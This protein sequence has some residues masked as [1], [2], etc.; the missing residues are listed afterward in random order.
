MKKVSSKKAW[1]FAVVSALFI[2]SVSAAYAVGSNTSNR[3]V[4]KQEDTSVLSSLI[5]ENRE[6]GKEETV[7]VLTDANGLAKKIIVSD[8]LK[9]TA[10]SKTISDYTELENVENIKG[11]ETYVMDKDNM[12]VW[13]AEGSDIYY[14]GT[15]D[16]TLPVDIKVSY[17]LDGKNISA[18]DL[19]GKSGRVTIRFDYQNNLEETVQIDGNNEIIHVPFVMLTGMILDN[20]HFKNIE[21]SNGKLINDA[22]KSLVMGFALPGLQDNLKLS[23]LELPSYVEIKADVE[24]FELTTTLSIATNDIFNHLNVENMNSAEDLK[25]ALND[26]SDASMQLVDGSSALYDGLSA[27]LSKSDELILGIDQLHKGS[28]Q[29]SDG[30]L[31]LNEG[32]VQLNSG[33][34]ELSEGLKL[35]ESNNAA[36]NGGAGQVFESLLAMADQQLEAAGLDVPLL[37]IENYQEVLESI[38]ASLDSDAIREMAYNTALSQ[39]TASIK[40]NESII[41]EQVE[42]EIR[43]QVLE[44]V[45]KAAG[46]NM[47]A[48]EYE[49]AL[50][51]GMIPDEIA[52]QIR[53]AVEMQMS[54][55]EIQNEISTVTEQKIEEL[56]QAAMQ[57]EEVLSK[58]EAAV[59]QAEQGRSRISSLLDQLKSYDQFYQGLLTYT[60]HVSEISNGVE[61]LKSGSAALVEGSGALK[62]G[63]WQLTAGLDNLKQG[64][65][66]L[67]DGVGELQKGS[68]QLSEGMKQFNDDGI[69]KIVDALEGNI[70]EAALRLKATIDVSKKYQSFAGK[71][72][73]M[74]GTVKFIYRTDAIE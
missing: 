16:K 5:D 40:E 14:Q 73:E 44:A 67:I 38:L 61:Q 47:S 30:A 64:S 63:I 32:T 4:E 65:N 39:V 52:N 13:N 3:I 33:A 58:I 37:T 42:A 9:N 11:D 53:T 17:Q 18:E 27:L 60:S 35:L 24:S 1:S 56:I 59:M 6:V 26:L 48:E 12:R 46:Q 71:N 25:K 57:S 49:Q 19:A 43:R 69:T 54:S 55:E 31:A 34:A 50:N 7:Y 10:S 20:A 23:D 22:D 29:L 72:S 15:I 36:L 8:W 74:T 68:M 66:A 41:R 21:V 2:S 70:S 45:L 28:Q 51:A 62:A